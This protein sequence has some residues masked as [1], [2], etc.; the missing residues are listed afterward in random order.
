MAEEVKE[1][2]VEENPPV[3]EVP[4]ARTYSEDEYNALKTQLE[5]L[6]QSTKDN[7][8]F[9]AKWEQSEKARKDFE[10]QTKI[11]EFI[12][13]QNLENDI[14]E[15]HLKKLIMEKELR[16]DENELVGGSKLVEKFKEKY[17]QA[18]KSAKIP[19]FADNTQGKAS[20]VAE[21]TLRKIMGL[22]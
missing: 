18:F 11:N 9:K 5:S 8:D 12:K 22:K 19:R 2:Q 10:Y 6:Q 3:E 13:A 20:S 1:T 16:F 15:E 21:D 4:K 7:E 14:Y 17:P